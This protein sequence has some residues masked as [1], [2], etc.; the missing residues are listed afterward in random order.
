MREKSRVSIVD[1]AHRVQGR[2]PIVLCISDDPET[3]IGFE[4]RG[5]DGVGGGG[6]PD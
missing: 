6:M 4:R 5:G 1:P 2:L 3:A